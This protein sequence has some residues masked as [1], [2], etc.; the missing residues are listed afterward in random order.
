MLFSTL[1]SSA[2][3]AVCTVGVVVGGR[4][5]DVI[6]NMREV[7]PGAPTWLVDL[8]YYAVPNFRNFDFKDKVVYGDPVSGAVLAWITLYA[9]LYGAFALG[10]GL[11]VFR[12]RD[13]Q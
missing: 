1:T 2:L 9:V 13:F 3:A 5:S 7:A 6:R 10:L 11:L 12:S 4:Y 8:L